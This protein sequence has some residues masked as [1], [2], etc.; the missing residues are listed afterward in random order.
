MNFKYAGLF[1]RPTLRLLGG[2]AITLP[3]GVAYVLKEYDSEVLR[4]HER[5]HLDQVKRYGAIGFTV[6]Y[7]WWLAKY[8]YWWHPMEIEARVKSKEEKAK[9]HWL[10]DP[11]L[12]P[13]L[14]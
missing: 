7:L 3:W 11:V 2:H 12:G 9:E 6:R 1:W 8:G 5:V 4:E 13:L 10:K 14:K